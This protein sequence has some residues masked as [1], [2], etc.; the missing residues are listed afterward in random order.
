MVR[1]VQRRGIDMRG[2]LLEQ[3]S[4]SPNAYAKP[5]GVTNGTAP[6]Q[7]S[8]ILADADPVASDQWAGGVHLSVLF[9]GQ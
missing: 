3:R 8:M 9:L 5:L 4:A 7:V 6:I 2:W 1:A